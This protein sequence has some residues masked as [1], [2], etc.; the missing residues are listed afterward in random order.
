[1]DVI[2]VDGVDAQAA[3]AFFTFFLDLL[4]AGADLDPHVIETHLGSQENA[5][6][7]PALLEPAPE[8]AFAFTALKTLHPMGID[9]G[10]VDKRTARIQIL[11]S[12]TKRD[13]FILFGSK[14]H[15]AEA[16]GADLG[17]AAA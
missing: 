9:V 12:E 16:Q 3:Q 4:W 8:Q 5:A 10:G 14:I 2:E 13:R 15:G 11:D 17:T 1:M 7:V 6:A